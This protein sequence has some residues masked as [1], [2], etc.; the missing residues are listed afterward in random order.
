MSPLFLLLLLAS[1]PAAALEPSA[2]PAIAPTAEP[3]P[4]A[5]SATEPEATPVPT[6]PAVAA[7]P[8]PRFLHDP[9][10]E[11]TTGADLHLPAR[12]RAPFRLDQLTLHYLVGS[13]EGWKTTE[14][15]RSSDGT[16]AAVVPAADVVVAGLSYY[17][18]AVGEGGVLQ[19]VFASQ[20]WPHPV[21]I[22]GDEEETRRA[23]ELHRT[24]GARSE[25]RTRVEWV[26]FSLGEDKGGTPDRY[27]R[28]EA[29]F[30]YLLLGKIDEIV[31][32]AGVLRGTAPALPEDPTGGE[33]RAYNYGYSELALRPTEK[34]AVFGKLMLGVNQDDFGAGFEGR[35]EIG[36]FSS[37][38]MELAGGG[39]QSLGSW[40]RVGMKWDTVPG[41]MMGA[42]VE[43]TSLPLD[44][45]AGVRLIYDL[46]VPVAD[47][48]NL[49]A[50]A[51]YQAR[52]SSL[53][54][55]SLGGG[56]TFRF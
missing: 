9:L 56:A 38:R 40:G 27:Y 28:T 30:R 15:R 32:G 13:S 29:E 34:F 10:R 35:M 31:I 49:D 19:P 8:L 47:W 42:A 17:V 48:L 54:G 6:A 41:V 5:P 50:R 14:F 44:Q 20:E 46:S 45:D 22:H 37:T 23:A 33:V 51:G 12:V 21:V 39:I 11:A 16:F 52:G 18:T 4:A 55:P 36:R 1:S 25:V 43:L 2:A 26:D 7:P 53:G 24:G 3:L